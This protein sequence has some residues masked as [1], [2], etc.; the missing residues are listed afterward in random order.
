MVTSQTRTQRVLD[1]GSIVTDGTVTVHSVSKPQGQPGPSTYLTNA[2]SCLVQS[3]VRFSQPPTSHSTKE[4]TLN[5]NNFDKFYP[6]YSAI[7]LPVNPAPLTKQLIPS[8][9][10]SKPLII[11]QTVSS[12][13]QSRPCF[14]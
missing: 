11:P 3:S 5:P 2:D 1:K 9:S 10:R 7:N 8:I 13:C 6:P 12:V 4:V 14:S